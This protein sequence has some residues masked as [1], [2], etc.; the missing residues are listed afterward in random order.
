ME[1]K[2]YGKR[3]FWLMSEIENFIQKL[4]RGRDLPISFEYIH[5]IYHDISHEFHIGLLPISI[6]QQILYA[7]DLEELLQTKVRL[8]MPRFDPNNDGFC[9][10]ETFVLFFQYITFVALTNRE[11]VEIGSIFDIIDTENATTEIITAK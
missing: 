5:K 6:F 4:L 8:L 1:Q 3:N 7:L 11:Y 10:E 2:L 9:N